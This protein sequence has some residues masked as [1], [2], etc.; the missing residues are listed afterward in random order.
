MRHYLSLPRTGQ[1]A[2]S[3]L[4]PSQQVPGAQ[5][6]PGDGGGGVDPAKR[7]WCRAKGRRP[8][9]GGQPLAPEAP[10][11]GW[12][13]QLPP[14]P[15]PRGSRQ[16][17]R[18]DQVSCPSSPEP[19]KSPFSGLRA[20]RGTGRMSGPCRLLAKAGTR[21][22]HPEARGCPAWFQPEWGESPPLSTSR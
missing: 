10:A 2:G 12:P 5:D 3:S 1:G 21:P 8:A 4:H 6:T 19:T 11:S 17:L 15:S 9:A 18:P 20:G 7:A 22:S 13:S 16:L 14:H